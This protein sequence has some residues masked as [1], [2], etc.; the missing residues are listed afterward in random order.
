MTVL[1]KSG[2]IRKK[3]R[4]RKHQH[5]ERKSLSTDFLELPGRVRQKGSGKCNKNHHKYRTVSIQRTYNPLR[6]KR[7]QEVGIWWK[8]TKASC[9][10]TIR[11]HLIA[12]A[13]F[14]TNRFSSHRGGR[15]I[16]LL[17]KLMFWKLK[18]YVVSS[19]DWTSSQKRHP[20]RVTKFTEPH[21]AQEVPEL[22]IAGG[23][24]SIEGSTECLLCSDS[25]PGIQLKP[26]LEAGYRATWTLD[27]PW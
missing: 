25:P 24:K 10:T 23:L 9:P 8:A 4:F 3:M 20:L 18:V 12:E 6:W 15:Y 21:L 11:M 5:S 1:D 7:H 22:K 27:L 16:E 17:V 14:K 2:Q 13:N 19:K 26:P